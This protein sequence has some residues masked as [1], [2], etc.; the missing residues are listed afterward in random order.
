MQINLIDYSNIFSDYDE[1]WI[2]TAPDGYVVEMYTDSG[3]QTESCCDSMN[4]ECGED[5]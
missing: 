2:I 1:C 4:I 3:F 5:G